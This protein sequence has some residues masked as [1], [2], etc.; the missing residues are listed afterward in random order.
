VAEGGART[1]GEDGGRRFLQRLYW[2]VAHRVDAWM[3]AE[4]MPPLV[5]TENPRAGRAQ[6]QQ[7]RAGDVRMLPGGDVGDFRRQVV[8]ISHT[9]MSPERRP[10]P[11]ARPKRDNLSTN[12]HR[13]L[14]HRSHR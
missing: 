4:R 14:T 5:L 2:G 10:F 9:S 6:R 11:P 1:A 8:N 7:L 13:D 3:D 12:G